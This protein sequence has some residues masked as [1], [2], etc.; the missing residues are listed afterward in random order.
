MKT[1]LFFILLVVTCLIAGCEKS[2]YA[3]TSPDGKIKEILDSTEQT[4][5]KYSYNKNWM[6]TQ[7]WSKEDLYTP[8]EKAEYTYTFDS[9]HK[10][11]KKKGYEP[12]NMIMSSLTGA[13]GK[14]VVYSYTYNESGQLEKI[15]VEY[16]Y[17]DYSDLDYKMNY[18]YEYPDDSK[19]IESINYVNPLANSIASHNEYQF[20]SNE[21][22]TKITNYYLLNGSDKRIVSETALTYDNQK[23]PFSFDPAP[24]S[25]NNLLTKN[26]TVYNYNEAGNQTVA[27]TSVY[28]YEYIYNDDGYPVQQTEIMPNKVRIIRNFKY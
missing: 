21:N 7:S 18:T 10:L 25:K 1:Q 2:E 20:D 27:Y 13:M 19:I 12:G 6:L 22:I 8:G 9:E 24:S 17:P 26:I 11:T 15:I 3:P 14:N 23:V 4:I 16:N 28:S 5:G